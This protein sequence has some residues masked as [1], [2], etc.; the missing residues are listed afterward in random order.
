MTRLEVDLA[1]I[2][3]NSSYTSHSKLRNKFQIPDAAED[4]NSPPTQASND[5]HFDE[6]ATTLNLYSP[7]KNSS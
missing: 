1:S 3:I 4:N 7:A 6:T 2:Y 5:T